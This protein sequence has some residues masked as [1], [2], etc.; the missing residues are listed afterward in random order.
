MHIYKP[1]KRLKVVVSQW[2]RKVTSEECAECGCSEVHP[3]HNPTASFSHDAPQITE[4]SVES[5]Q[6]AFKFKED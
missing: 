1:Y 2:P 4:L 6:M 3:V 5:A